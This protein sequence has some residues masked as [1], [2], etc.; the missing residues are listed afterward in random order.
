[1]RLKRQRLIRSL[2]DE[3]IEMYA[4]RDERLTAHFSKNFSGYTGGG[5]FLVKN[6]DEWVKIT[7]QDFN[8][9]PG[10]IRIEMLNLSMQDL[11]DD[12]VV[13]T[14][15][16][17]IHL[18]IPDQVLSREAVRL[19]LVFRLENN[20]WKIAHS[21]ISVPYYLVREGEVYPIKGLYERNEELEVLLQERTLAL[22]EAN[23]KLD[24]QNRL[25]HKVR[26][27]LECRLEDDTDMQIVAQA[28]NCSSRTLGRRLREEG[29]TFLQIKDAMRREI[30]I[31]LLTESNKSV[32]AVSEQ[33]GFTSMAAFHRAFKIWTGCTPRAFRRARAHY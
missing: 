30:A 22:E 18:P 27:Y 13:A 28:L 14:A 5:D 20:K 12:V 2:F 6:R 15:L 32:E 10:R 29:T 1:M 11:S 19:T 3:Y 25:S 17:H 4:S 16:F 9:V 23:R 21:G 8:Q 33:I 26:K 7:R 24:E 31:R